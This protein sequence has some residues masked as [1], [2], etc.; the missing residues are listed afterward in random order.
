[1][2]LTEVS[3]VS[4]DCHGDGSSGLRNIEAAVNGKNGLSWAGAG[5]WSKSRISFV[6]CGEGERHTEE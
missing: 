6:T 5:S 4:G 3:T 1:I 2:T